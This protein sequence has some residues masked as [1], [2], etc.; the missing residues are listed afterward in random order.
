MRRQWFASDNF[1]IA[2]RG[3]FLHVVKQAIE[4][5]VTRGKKMPVDPTVLESGI[6]YANDHAFPRT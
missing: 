1:S 5:K 2:Q 6:R 4:R 3:L